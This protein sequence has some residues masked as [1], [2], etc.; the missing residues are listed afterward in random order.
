MKQPCAVN[1]LHYRKMLLPI[2]NTGPE[3]LRLEPGR[4]IDVV[5]EDIDPKTAGD[6]PT[7]GHRLRSIAVLL[8]KSHGCAASSSLIS[9]TSA[10][11]ALLCLRAIHELPG[12]PTAYNFEPNGPKGERLVADKQRF[13]P[14]VG[15]DGIFFFF[16]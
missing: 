4:P 2:Q 8:R 13:R 16:C 10:A 3:D 15:E 1:R 11:V 7:V 5:H 9:L 14:A 6:R 12:P